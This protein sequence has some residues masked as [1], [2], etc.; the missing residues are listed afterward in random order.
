MTGTPLEAST[1]NLYTRNKHVETKVVISISKKVD[2]Q[3]VKMTCY[4]PV[5]KQLNFSFIYMERMRV[6]GKRKGST[7]IKLQKVCHLTEGLLGDVSIAAA[8][9]TRLTNNISYANASTVF[10]HMQDRC[11]WLTFSWYGSN[12]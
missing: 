12:C 1:K 7:P 8:I 3:R 2:L 9:K 11:H 4:N 10:N 6:Q 5:S